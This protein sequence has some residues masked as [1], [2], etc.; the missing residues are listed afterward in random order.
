[1]S[2]ASNRNHQKGAATLVVVM[3]LF[4]I[5]SLV[6]A[7]TSRN[8]IFEQRTSANQYRSSQ[9][10]EAAE[11]GLEWAL[12]QLNFGRITTTCTPSSNTADTTFRQRY[13]DIDAST[14]KILARSITPAPAPPASPAPLTPQC[15]FDAST[16]DWNCSCPVN[17]A[18]VLNAPAGTAVAP[19]FR[20]R[21]V[22]INPLSALPP[23][24]PN[25]IRA[26]VVGCTRL[27]N[28][29]LDF[30][31]QGQTNEGRVVISSLIALTGNVASMPLAAL[32]SRGAVALTPGGAMSV[33]NGA[34]GSLGLTVQSG[35]IIDA[36]IVVQTTAGTP[37]STSLVPNDPALNLVAAAPYSASDRMFI[38]VFSMFR[39]SFRQQQGGVQKACA[40]GGCSTGS[41]TTAGDVRNLIA[42][43]PGRPIWLTDSLIVDTPG[44]IG[45][46]AEPVLLVVNGDVVFN[47]GGVTIH[48]LV[49]TRPL[50]PATNPDWVTSGS[51][52]FSGAVVAEGGV[53]VGATSNLNI[54]YNGDTLNILRGNTGTFARVPS[55]WA[56][57]Q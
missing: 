22:R 47:V 16:S 42:L 53:S 26:E 24:Q 11:A 44:D 29:C 51:G 27:D 9:A 4:F 46:A 33:Y 39:D 14:G 54:N 21:F 56:D 5:I 3:V 34:S 13:L 38:A 12:T 30:E 49:Y 41:A 8:M 2:T 17:G 48:G 55:S 50:A 6:A 18:P 32:T 52:Q 45:S 37:A 20:V 19:A 40:V 1:M 43:N 36:G 15:V 10:F 35:G 7:Y 28:A 23:A 25:V 57:Y 31:G